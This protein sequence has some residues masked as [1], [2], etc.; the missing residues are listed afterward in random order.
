M[1]GVSK[2]MAYMNFVI[3][4]FVC[5]ALSCEAQTA[6]LPQIR[7]NGEVKQFF[8]DG[9]PYIMLSGELHNSSP[10]SIE[11][12]Q[13]IWD[14]LAVLHLNTVIGAASWE[15][16]EPTEG[17]FDFSLVDDQINQ[18]RQ[19]NMRLVLIWFAT[20][21]NAGSSYPPA[22]V[23]ADPKRFPPMVLNVKAD[24]GVGSFLAKYMEQQ[25]TGPLSPF[26]KE[27]VEA[28]ARAF[29]ALMSHIK[30]VDAQHTVIMMQVENEMGSLG[31]SRDHS[32]KAEAAWAGQVPADL[33]DYLTKHKETLLPEV[34]EVWGKNGY[35]AKGSWKEVFGEG[36]WAGEIFM[37]Y[38]MGRY[39]NEVAKE[40]KAQLNIPMYVNAWLGPQPKAEL[41]GQ[42]P[43]GGPVAGVMDIYR[44][45]APSIDLL[46]PD[47]Y[48][49]DFKGTCALYARSGN[50][51]FIPEARDQVGNLFWALGHHSALGWS[52][53]GVEDL[54]P[55]GQV[56]QAYKLLSPMLSQLAEW[57][58]AG[59]VNGILVIDGEK[60]EPV[61]LGGYKITLAASRGFGASAP[62]PESDAELGAGASSAS[63]AMPSDKRPFAIV[64]NTAPDEFLFIGANGDPAFTIESGGGKVFISSKD[65]GRYENGK[66][67]AGRR[68]N[69]DEVFESGLPKA[70][71]GM[72]KVKLLRMQ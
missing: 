29:A 19:R 41:P 6:P 23:K 15:L 26:G 62:K 3:C 67:I 46:A 31:D 68:I 63:R 57:Q 55:D 47:I 12:M 72:L 34:Q 66:W 45:A 30:D 39:V 49:P 11:Y 18:A 10:S 8:V 25:G 61:S 38:Y 71:V 40:G 51:L 44:A 35:K 50:P 7:Q 43:S 70:R 36:E 14:K 4:L 27:T 69:G 17:K 28:D 16:V 22:W 54:S 24:G 21:K 53:F 2:R 5:A 48:V 20:W 32:P 42:W 65:E 37:A 13:P 59:K 33:M 64:V 60:S 1:N 52:P 9:K 58:A 56:A